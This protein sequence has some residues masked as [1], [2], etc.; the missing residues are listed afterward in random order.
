MNKNLTVIWQ[1]IVKYEFFVWMS[2]WAGFVIA[3]ERT[4][5]ANIAGISSLIGLIA[6]TRLAMNPMWEDKNE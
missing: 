2:I 5:D 6:I 1:F 3:Y 4:E